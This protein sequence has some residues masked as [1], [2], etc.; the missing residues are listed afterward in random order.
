MTILDV[1]L[2]APDDDVAWRN[3]EWIITNGLGGYASGTIAGVCTRR[4]HGA[5]VPNL[6]HPR[7]RHVLVSRLDEELIIDG[8]SYCLNGC[9]QAGAPPHPGA[10]A[11][12]RGFRLDGN[13]ACWTFVCGDVTLERW[14]VMPHQRNTVYVRYEITRGPAARIRVR[15]FLPF[16]RQDAP[17]QKPGYGNFAVAISEDE[18]CRIGLV[19]H[20]MSLALRV[21]PAAAT[22]VPAVEEAASLLWREQVR[23]Y[24]CHEALA[25]PGH[26][27]WPLEPRTPVVMVM[28][29]EELHPHAQTEAPFEAERQRVAQLVAQAG[30]QSD[31]FLARLVVAADQ[32]LILPE[33]RVEETSEAASQ[34]HAL[35][36][37]VAGYHWFLDWGR[38]TMISL[39]GLMLATGRHA[40]ARATL[41]TFSHYVRDGLLP[42]LFPEGS[43][44]G[45]Y[46]TVDATLWYFHAIHRYLITTLDQ[47]LLEDLLPTLRD[48][49]RHHFEGTRF[50]IGMDR[51]DGLL[52]AGAE[53]NALT[54]MDAH[55]GDWIVTPRRGKPVEIQ[56]LW[57][58]ALRLMQQ[59][60]TDATERENYARRAEIARRSFNARFW[61]PAGNCL[62]D[63][64]DGEGGNDS[65]LRP[66]QLFAI[67]LDHPVL[68]ASRWPAV[69]ET[70]RDQLLTPVGLRTLDPRDRDYSRNYHGNLR[71]RDAAYHQGTVWPWL[72][73]AYIDA[74]LRIHGDAAQVRSL[75][76]AF[77]GHLQ[78]A[79]IGSIS[80]VF[81][82]DQPHVP[83]GC[84]AQ[85]WSVA[86]VLRCWKRTL[87][88]IAPAPA[89]DQRGV[90]SM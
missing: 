52:R 58:N 83:H 7:G 28:T 20:E 25:S 36:T 51:D 15:P 75:L 86:E 62:F 56:A 68:D 54:W 40:E 89:C 48:I 31:A 39:E 30:A 14:M 50:H 5:F 1:T 43:R 79:G 4:Y 8:R 66:N 61:N 42:N 13:I 3:R 80:E 16:R 72:L 90:S 41:L 47:T 84:I 29:T 69:L 26:F 87:G 23:G 38:D 37:V 73:G 46:H 60:E 64:V 11:W 12:L 74:A 34:G 88:A 19:D 59:W 22:F 9:D 2:P 32:F 10:A 55:M 49:M 24:D 45:W 27:E 33:N 78:V 18:C 63:V 44:E 76:A 81:D 71:S 77:P 67:S 53:H 65:R 35:R 57:Y 70:V 21:T 82:G 6:T 85:A 17:L